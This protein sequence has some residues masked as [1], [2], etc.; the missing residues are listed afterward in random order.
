MWGDKVYR[1]NV[2]DKKTIE[3]VLSGNPNE[4]EMRAFFGECDRVLKAFPNKDAFVL[5]DISNLKYSGLNG[6]DTLDKLKKK[7]EEYCARVAVVVDNMLAQAYVNVSFK[8]TK[9][10][11]SAFRSRDEAL[12]FLH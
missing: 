8:D 4:S 9:C 11:V 12:R 5:L 6:S 7:V 3:A 10:R 2:I 1:I